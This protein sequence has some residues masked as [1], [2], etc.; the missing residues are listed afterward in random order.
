MK[1]VFVFE[2]LTGGGPVDGD[3][4]HR[5]AL[6]EQG[7]QMRDAMVDD[8]LLAGDWAVTAATCRDVAAP[9]AGAL[10]AVAQPGEPVLAWL[11]RQAARHDV[12]WAVAPETDDLL[13]R[14]RQ[15]VPDRCWHGCD[16]A[17]IALTSHKR[18]TLDRLASFGLCTPLA[19]AG[20]ATRWVLK[21]DDGAG[22][23]DT[24]VH[25]NV[26]GALAAAAP[27]AQCGMTVEPWVDGDAMSLS[28][29][30]HAGSAELL[31]INRQHIRVDADGQ[32]VFG[33]VEIDCLPLGSGTGR[34]LAALAQR[35]LHAVPGLGGF[36]GVDLV[37]HAARGP[38]V[39]EINPRLTT[40]YVGLSA[41]L[42]RQLAAELLAGRM[43]DVTHE[44]AHAVA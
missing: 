32:V 24:T 15:A 7:R 31:S 17:S 19:F 38:V 6:R 12:V 9:P 44:A 2:Y 8:L 42:G 39:I 27:F 13:L 29:N 21:P 10:P 36:V 26:H 43:A 4:A 28:L 40:A 22:T 18:A 37:W 34:A 20:E 33:G 30:C 25:P 1:R 41:R 5:R 11:A 23:I 14:C 35:L 3:Q 16:A